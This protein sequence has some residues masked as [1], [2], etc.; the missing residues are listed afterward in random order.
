MP[1]SL[2]KMLIEFESVLQALLIA[3]DSFSSQ[4]QSLLMLFQGVRNA[5]IEIAAV[6]AGAAVTT[7]AAD[8]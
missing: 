7:T 6:A 8:A 1:V 5:S 2:I 4:K 3:T